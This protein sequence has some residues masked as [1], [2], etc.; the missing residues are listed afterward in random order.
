MAAKGK[1]RKSEKGQSVIEFMIM[2]PVMIAL[3]LLLLQ[4]CT[5]IQIGIVG[6]KYARSETLRIAANSPVFPALYVR[7]PYMADPQYAYNQMIVGT[8][9]EKVGSTTQVEPVAP[10]VEIARP[11]AKHKGSNDRGEPNQRTAIRI[12]STVHLC[13]QPNVIG[14]QPILPLNSSP[15]FEPTGLYRLSTNGEIDLCGGS[16]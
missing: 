15:P 3:P 16:P 13:T 2:L 7:I 10:M 9:D 8:S 6:Q 14:G 5:A 12:R 11:G 1:Y 4:V